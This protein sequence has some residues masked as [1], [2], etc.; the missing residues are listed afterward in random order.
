MA[1]AGEN[2]LYFP[3]KPHRKL[4]V[5]SA[6]VKAGSGSEVLKGHAGMN[7]PNRTI[8]GILEIRLMTYLHL[9]LPDTHQRYGSK[10]HGNNKIMKTVS[11]E[12]SLKGESIDDLCRL[13]ECG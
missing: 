8:S 12:H 13:D 5:I 6:R 4:G 10:T 3:Y 11:V 9:R 7:S 2:Y 1:T